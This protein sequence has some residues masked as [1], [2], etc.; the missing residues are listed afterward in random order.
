VR[1]LL[2]LTEKQAKLL[3]NILDGAMDAGAGGLGFSKEENKE[4]LEIDRQLFRIKQEFE[5]QRKMQDALEA[6]MKAKKLD[7]KVRQAST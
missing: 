1:K 2:G 3:F 7:C 4:L 5:E 6:P